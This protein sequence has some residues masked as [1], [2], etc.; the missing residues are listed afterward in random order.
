MIKQLYHKAQRVLLILL[1]VSAMLGNNMFAQVSVSGPSCIISET[2]YQYVINGNW[3]Q[4]SW[5]RVCITGG[6]LITGNRCMTGNVVVSSVFVIWKDTSYRKLE[7]N[8]SSGNIS[9]AVQGTT[10]LNGGHLHDSDRVQVYYP[11]RASYSFR[12]ETASGGACIPDYLYRWQKSADGLNWININGATGKDLQFSGNIL[13]NTFFRRVTTEIKSNSMA[14]SD[15]GIL[16]IRF[17]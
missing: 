12:C 14:Y 1:S 4:P 10:K 3:K 9:L 7:I 16:T 2:T 8:S 11:A 13:V 6:K 5:M 15:T 17:N